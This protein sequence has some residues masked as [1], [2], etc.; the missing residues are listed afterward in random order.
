MAEHNRICTTETRLT[1]HNIPIKI[2]SDILELIE[3]IY[4]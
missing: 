4:R 2:I 1:I 3:P